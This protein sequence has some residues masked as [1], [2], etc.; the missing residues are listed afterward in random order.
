MR[1]TSEDEPSVAIGQD[2]GLA[3]GEQAGAVCPRQD[4]D[5]DRDLAQLGH[6]TTVHPDA[7]VE[8]E[9][10]GGL[11]LDEA[12][13]VLADARL[14]AGAL[15]E[16][17]AVATG[18]VRPDR[19]GDRLAQGLEP[20]RQVVAEPD[21]QVGGRLGVGECPVRLGELDAEEVRQRRE[22][23][24]LEVRIALAGDRQGVEIAARLDVGAVGERR[25]DEGEVEADRVTDD[26]RVADELEGL[27]DGLGRASGPS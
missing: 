20:A 22:L 12:E 25:L 3:A 15:E 8:G 18:P 5:V 24:V 13:Q 26:L 17:L 4:A 27:L 11:L 14:A 21:E 1:W 23:V 7:L 16:G 9:L 19:V 2:L 10:A 6:A